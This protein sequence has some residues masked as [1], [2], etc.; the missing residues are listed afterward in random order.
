MKFIKLTLI[1]ESLT[2]EGQKRQ[3]QELEEY[4]RMKLK[5][6]GLTP[7]DQ[8]D[9]DLDPIEKA[10]RESEKLYGDKSKNK[11]DKVT[12]EI[13]T[14]DFHF[15]PKD[16]EIEKMEAIYAVNIS[17]IIDMQEGMDSTYLDLARSEGVTV[18]ETIDEILEKIVAQ[19]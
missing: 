12:V 17:D 13:D 6:E 11:V 15:I 9:E 5:E 4:M 8:E 3:Q 10:I 7:I 2:K 19:Q 16:Q 1:Y 18:K 14:K